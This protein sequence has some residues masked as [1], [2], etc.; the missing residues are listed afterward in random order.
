MGGPTRGRPEEPESRLGRIGRPNACARTGERA[1]PVA[2]RNT[3]HR[4]ADKWVEQ[5]GPSRGEQRLWEAQTWE[6]DTLPT[7][8]LPLGLRS[9]RASAFR[10]AH[11][12]CRRAENWCGGARCTDVPVGP[13]GQSYEVTD[14]AALILQRVRPAQQRARSRPRSPASGAIWR[15]GT[16]HPRQSE[17]WA[18]QSQ[19]SCECERCRPP[20]S[21]GRT[22]VAS[23]LV[24]I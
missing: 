23:R 16:S 4:R 20:E 18:V 5:E 3:R 1:R 7:E 21:W 10:R 17:P 22:A 9:L 13:R 11:R 24:V 19:A 2:R 8:L 6:A 15:P 12:D 14:R